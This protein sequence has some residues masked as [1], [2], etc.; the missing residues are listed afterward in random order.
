MALII[1]V[2]VFGSALALYGLALP[3]PAR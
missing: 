1:L 3:K 2:S